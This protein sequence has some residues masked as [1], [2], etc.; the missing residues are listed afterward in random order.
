MFYGAAYYPEQRKPERWEHDLDQMEKARINTLRVGEFA[1]CF[2][3]PRLGHYD[4][5]WM[6]RFRDLA[7]KRGI[8]LLMCPPL[9]TL[10][11]WF[12]TRDPSLR[13]VLDTGLPLEYGSR[14]SFCINHPDLRER[15]AALAAA[16]A[17]HYGHD[18]AVVGWHLDNE[19]G[20]EP[21]CHCPICRT[22]FQ[23]WLERKYGPIAELNEAWGLAFWGLRFDDFQ[24]IPTTRISKTYH[25]PGHVLDWRRFRS[26]CTVDAA[27]VQAN[28]VRP[29]MRKGQFIT[30]NNQAI[31]NGR[32]DYYRMAEILDVAGTNYY[33]PYGSGS[34]LGIGEG[35][36]LAQ[37]R[38]YQNGRAFHIHELRCGPHVVPGRGANDPAPGEVARL[39]M[40][41]VANGSDGLFFF[42]W[43]ACPFGAEQA[44]GTITDY[45]GHPTR[46]FPE[47]RHVGEWLEKHGELVDS[48]AVKARTAVLIDFQTRWTSEALGPEWG[49]PRGFYPDQTVKVYGA[50]RRAGIAVDAVSRWSEW[51]SYDVLAVPA[52]ASCDDE[53]ADK[54]AAYVRGGGTLIAQPLV[55]WKDE[56][57]HVHVGRLHPRLQDM[58]GFS[59]ADFATLDAQ[60]K[61]TFEW[62][63]T[64]YAG[65]LFAELPDV[66]DD[67]VEGR[68]LEG[69][70]KG[71]PAVVRNA[72][73][74]GAVWWLCSY[75][76]KAFL[77][78]LA[79]ELCRERGI[80]PI[81]S[82]TVPEDVEVMERQVPDGRRL[83]FVLSASAEPRTLKVPFP[84]WDLYADA[85]VEGEVTLPPYGV[86]VL[87]RRER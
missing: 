23:I 16:M 41:S 77:T 66:S 42:R 84:A 74:K 87:V 65:T 4:F 56:R 55:G 61:T 3:E 48:T 33:P 63:G 14:Y 24:Q 75:A 26:E 50:M 2:F 45:D 7:A 73:G 6:D 59:F 72:A 13:L 22:M 46:I 40:H 79:L 37:C 35:L 12:A 44:H 53:V 49:L 58:L 80:A 31:W 39:A 60:A 82:A 21:D 78:A 38:S 15:G 5:G 54:L 11:A 30:T 28:E 36:A 85:P 76:E 69:W 8:R 51:S 27:R 57:A 34:V 29:R 32:T 86:A 25:S 19:H 9:R 20:D 70:Y 83:V 71:R 68:F 10:P 17:K 18:Q 62:R 52:L 81:L 67:A 64:T 47:V 1:W 43:R